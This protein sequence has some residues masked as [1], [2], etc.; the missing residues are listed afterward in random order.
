MNAITQGTDP[1][2]S[3]VSA[4]G[5]RWVRWPDVACIGGIV[6]SGVWYLA[7]IPLIPS[8]VGTHPVLLEAMS[9]S[10]PSMVAAGAFAHVGR[11]SLIVALAAPI[12]GLS[13]FDPLWWWAGRRYGETIISTALA[14]SPRTMRA[15]NR[16]L[17]LFERLGGWTL[18]LAYYLPVPN[19][20]LYAA[21]GWAGFSFLRFAVL[22]L[23]GTLLRIVL[24]VG[25]G[26]ALG[27][28]AAHAAGLVSRYSIAA[29]VT[30]IVGLIMVAWWQRRPRRGGSGPIVVAADREPDN[31]AAAQVAEHLRRLVADG[32]VPGLV[33]AVITPTASAT[34]QMS[35]AGGDPLGPHVMME[36]GS[37]TKVFTALLLADMTERQEVSLE[38]PIALYLPAAV[39]STCP[40]A[41]RITLRQLATHTS[42]LPRIPRNL[43]PMAVGHLTDP[44]A[45][46]SAEHLYRA[47][48]KADNAA[49]APYRYS[50]YGFGLLGHLLSRTAGRPYGELIA[51]RVTGPL[52]LAETGIEVPD[53]LTAAVG[54]QG[55]RQVPHWHLDA[56][57]GAGALS[58]TASD[59]ARFL[60]ANLH[61]QTTPIPNVIETIQRRHPSP[62]GNQ[63]TG[64]GW[65]ISELSG[66]TI[67]WHNGGTGG[68]SSM[69]ALDR[70]AGCAV[71]AVATSGPTRNMPLDS[72][73]LAALTD[74]T[75]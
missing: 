34:G 33:Y 56:L 13:A 74:L 43:L 75:S 64:L 25:L 46:Y 28:R 54:H 72:A 45:G 62:P 66:R 30:L 65:H 53:G 7:V 40:A 22:D 5:R 38:D 9:G 16:G 27:G 11:V 39:A 50:N 19:N 69:L 20:V 6:L 61:P 70:Q 14:R 59:L 44:Y 41:T 49:P 23:I 12:I 71:A 67:L 29:T 52:G 68:F 31:A 3:P 42:G 21:A 4:S 73:V 51:D 32:T 35:C 36:I 1:V 18:V 60:H 47:L 57:A 26:Y 8:L 37:A 17:R 2:L 15:T 55:K 24:D 58:S 63:A 10:L 48:R